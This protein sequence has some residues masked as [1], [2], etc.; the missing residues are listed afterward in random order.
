MENRLYS[1]GW[2]ILVHESG[3]GMP[4][5]AQTT[6]NICRKVYQ[7]RRR[8]FL[9]QFLPLRAIRMWATESKNGKNGR[10][11]VFSQFFCLIWHVWCPTTHFRGRRVRWRG[12]RINQIKIWPSFCQKSRKSASFLAKSGT[13]LSR[14]ANSG[15]QASNSYQMYE[16]GFFPTK[17]TRNKVQPT[18]NLALFFENAAISCY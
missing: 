13:V 7:V 15:Q 4:I 5:L 1:G 10:F 9:K 14:W 3:L 6:P 16:K 18:L 8:N 11:S 17:G 2:E 12:F